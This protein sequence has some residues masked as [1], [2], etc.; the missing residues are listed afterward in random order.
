MGGFM[1]IDSSNIA[2]GAQPD[3][4]ETLREK[5]AQCRLVAA[6]VSDRTAANALRALAEDYE[7]DARHHAG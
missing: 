2:V 7:R 5:A 6:T 4:S 3:P 1:H